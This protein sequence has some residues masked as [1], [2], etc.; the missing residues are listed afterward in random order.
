MHD[1]VE[2]VS[3][4]NCCVFRLT[5][6]AYRTSDDSVCLFPSCLLELK[7]FLNDEVIVEICKLII[8]FFFERETISVRTCDKQNVLLKAHSVQL[9][10][11]WERMPK[12]RRQ[13]KM[14]VGVYAILIPAP[15]TVIHSV[16]NSSTCAFYQ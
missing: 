5:H 7:P 3:L 1:C 15:Q 12:G 16:F 6:L 13:T 9:F 8:F 11:L 2:T 4:Q 10:M 14:P